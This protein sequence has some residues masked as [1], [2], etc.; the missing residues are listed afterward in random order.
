MPE[1]SV[2]LSFA[3]DDAPF[4][5]SVASALHERGVAAW[6]D[7]GD[8]RAGEEFSSRLRDSLRGSKLVVVFVGNRPDSPWLNFEVGAAL[9]ES[10][11]VLPVFLSKRGLEAAPAVITELS[12]IDATGLTPE[13]VAKE[14]TDAVNVAA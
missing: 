11:A 5:E 14:I 2:F 13:Q 10:K 7:T 4:V 1:S 12:G 8:I 3:R 6:I 9:G